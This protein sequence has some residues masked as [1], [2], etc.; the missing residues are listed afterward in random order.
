MPYVS[1]YAIAWSPCSD[2]ERVVRDVGRTLGRKPVRCHLAVVQ[3]GGP[4]AYQ[5]GIER[6][7]GAHDRHRRRPEVAILTPI[8]GCLDLFTVLSVRFMAS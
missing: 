7:I 5:L 6:S 3:R 4:V 1:P 8:R 2:L